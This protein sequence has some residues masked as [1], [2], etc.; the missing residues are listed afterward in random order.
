MVSQQKHAS[1]EETDIWKPEHKKT[2]ALKNQST[3]SLESTFQCSSTHIQF[4]IESQVKIMM[5]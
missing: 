2:E 4:C 3:L 1:S 5:L